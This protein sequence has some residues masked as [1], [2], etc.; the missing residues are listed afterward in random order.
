MKNK[1]T[2]NNS[3]TDWERIDAMQEENIDLSDSPELTPEMFAKA[4]V[5]H[6]LQPRPKKIQFTL[7]VE[8][9]VLAWFR[10]QGAGYQTQMNN[11]LRAYM[12]ARNQHGQIQS[13]IEKPK[14]ML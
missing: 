7:R 8:E 12:E 5:R 14:Q 11:L 1:P 9:D 4:V 13:V 6:G 10:S 2:L 3:A